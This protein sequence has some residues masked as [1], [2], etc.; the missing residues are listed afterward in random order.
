MIKKIIIL[1]FLNIGF[2]IGLKSLVIPQ[3]ALALATSNSGIANALS[4][5][6]N[7]ASLN[8]IKPFL[9]FSKN[10]WIGDL[11]GQKISMLWEDNNI[12]SQLSFESLKINDIELRNEVASETPMG[13]FGAYWYAF[14]F[15]R[16]IKVTNFKLGYKIKFNH[17]KLY[18]ESM[19]GVTIDIGIQKKI[20]DSFSLGFV[21]KN[22][23]KEIDN[24]LS[25]KT[26]EFLGLGVSYQFP[27]SPMKILSDVVSQDNQILTKLLMQTDFKYINLILGTTRGD[28]Y[29][30][31]AFGI[32]LSIKEW[33]LIYG[34]LKHNNSALGNP[35]SIEIRTYF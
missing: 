17:S 2:S 4:A 20:N 30:D 29:T 19:H 24:N 10:T 6:I 32:N 8:T 13:F 18:T 33:S 15:S 28:E 25:A 11:K 16:S 31:V 22:Y 7:P 1:I 27:N 12:Y 3:S 34:N 21:L 23:G 9:G 35:V 26:P 14:D 5:D